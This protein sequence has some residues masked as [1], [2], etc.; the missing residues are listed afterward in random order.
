MF[1]RGLIIVNSSVAIQRAQVCETFTPYLGCKGYLYI[2]WAYESSSSIS[3]KI[4]TMYII[5]MIGSLNMEKYYV[6]MFTIPL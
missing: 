2:Q 3:S 5:R 6:Y 1:H 4:A